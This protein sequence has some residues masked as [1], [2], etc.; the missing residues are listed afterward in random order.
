[1]QGE[2]PILLRVMGKT[3]VDGLYLSLD[4]LRTLFVDRRLPPRITRRLE[5]KT[6]ALSA[7]T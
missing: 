5:E 2:W 4:E 6:S 7:D 1:M 3:S